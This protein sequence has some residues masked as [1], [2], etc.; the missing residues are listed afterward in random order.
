MATRYHR[1]LTLSTG[2]P[3]QS[4]PARPSGRADPPA[5]KRGRAVRRRGRRPGRRRGGRGGGGKVT[6]FPAA[7]RARP[8]RRRAAG[9]PCGAAGPCRPS[10][11]RPPLPG[12]ALRPGP[13][14][15]AAAGLAAAMTAEETTAPSMQRGAP[16]RP[17]LRLLGPPPGRTPVA[18]YKDQ[19]ALRAPRPPAPRRACRAAHRDS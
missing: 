11:L 8:P 17:A 13:A 18:D 6:S 9:R 12:A 5:S 7:E 14:G 16:R 15:E 19:H 4:L 2:S 10:G 3:P 1:S